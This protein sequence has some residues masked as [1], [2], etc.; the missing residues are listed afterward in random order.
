VI[1]FVGENGST[2]D[3]IRMTPWA[4][5]HHEVG[6]GENINVPTIDIISREIDIIGNLVGP[7]TTWWADGAGRAGEGHAA[8]GEVGPGPVQ[9]AIED[10]SAGRVRARAILI[11]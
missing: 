9:E 3:G 2:S 6:Y 1:D 8:H 10:L 4:G 5:D 11:P 7:A